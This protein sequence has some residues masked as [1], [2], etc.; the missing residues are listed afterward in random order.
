MGSHGPLAACWE[1]GKGEEGKGEVRVG[2][3]M[4]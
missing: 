4:L 2:L 3:K 1:E